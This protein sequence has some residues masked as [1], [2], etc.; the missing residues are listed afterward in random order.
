MCDLMGLHGGES[1]SLDNRPRRC[2]A[3]RDAADSKTNDAVWA[4]L[5]I[6]A[7]MIDG[8]DCVLDVNPAAED[9]FNRSAR[10]LAGK[11]V[12][13][14]TENG[15]VFRDS[16]NQVR[17]RQSPVL[18]DDFVVLPHG[19]D[20][21]AATVQVAPV[22]DEQSRLLVC[23]RSREIEG[24][25]GYGNRAKSAAR[26]A[27]GLA[28][29]LSHEIR[30]PLSGIVGAAQLLSM[31]LQGADLELT[32][33]IVEEAY[34]I[35]KLLEQVDQFGRTEAHECAA[36]N[37]HDLL[38]RACR[39]ANV[40]CAA[41]IRIETEYDPSLPDVWADRDQLLRVFLNLMQNS[42]EALG[43]TEGRIRIRTRYDRF[44][45]VRNTDGE[46]SALP[47]HVEIIDN[48]PGMSPEMA[49]S[50]FEP[51]V[52][53]RKNGTGL[54]LALVSAILSDLGGWISFDS[55]PGRTVFRV[56]LPIAAQAGMP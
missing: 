51:F 29:M 38:D 44:L 12:N 36:L 41:G 52:S 14:L 35:R 17:Q 10:S 30:N 4:S 13:V 19:R 46:D 18:V 55:Q 28:D 42:S 39:V 20:R 15:N 54:G 31:K 25:I 23:I 16:L 45:R 22:A 37:V 8:S 3:D 5:P 21:L 9:L 48:G 33:L 1:P 32:E 26:S 7:V 56:S 34:R 24:K 11:P 43:G 50:A 40:S 53:G 6:A 27:V 2:S 47:V 49:A